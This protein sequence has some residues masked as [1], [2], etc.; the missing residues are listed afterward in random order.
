MEGEGL[1][2]AVRKTRQLMDDPEVSVLFEAAFQVD[3]YAAR[4]DVLARD[5]GGWKVVEVK[6]SLHDE[7]V[8]DDLADDLAYTV[9]VASRCGID[10]TNASLL[11][12]SR[13]FRQGMGAEELF[14]ETDATALIRQRLPDF[15]ARWDEIREATSRSEPPMPVLGQACADCPYFADRCLGRGIEHAVWEIPRRTAAQNEAIR[16]SGIL[17]LRAIPDDFPL[18]DRQRRVV[19]CAKTGKPYVGDGLAAALGAVIFPVRYLDFETVMTALPLYPDIAPHV[20]VV[21]QYSVHECGEPGRAD[22]HFEYLADPSRD[23]RRELAERL[24]ADLGTEGS[25]VV[26]SSF[27]APAHR[28]ARPPVP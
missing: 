17:D 4:A 15:L 7:D 23:C 28:R 12:I 16:R 11:R 18:N 10:V 26:Y 21:T 13:D 22:R 25:I 24:V 3:G 2:D 20:Q 19:A 27:D 5:G 1:S 8:P 9:T 14:G 6:S